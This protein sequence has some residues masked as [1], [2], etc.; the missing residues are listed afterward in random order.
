MGCPPVQRGRGQESPSGL[1]AWRPWELTPREAASVNAANGPR[2]CEGAATSGFFPPGPPN[3]VQTRSYKPFPHLSLWLCAPEDME[4]SIPHP[5]ETACQ[6]GGAATLRECG[7]LGIRLG[8]WGG[9]VLTIHPKPREAGPRVPEGPARVQARVGQE[10]ANP[11]EGGG[12]GGACTP[13]TAAQ[14]PLPEPR[15]HPDLRAQQPAVELVRMTQSRLPTV[16]PA[17]CGLAQTNQP[18]EPLQVRL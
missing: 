3:H 4:P 1:E 16:S 15:V 5:E 11:R 13:L 2:S 12:A 18:P 9:Q 8:G 10:L 14:L 7:F 17:R 6:A